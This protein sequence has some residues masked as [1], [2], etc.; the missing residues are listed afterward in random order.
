MFLSNSLLSLWCLWCGL[1]VDAFS[2]LSVRASSDN[3]SR[4][5]RPFSLS[6][7]RQAATLPVANEVEFDEQDDETTKNLKD[8]LELD[9]E[10]CLR[11]HKDGPVLLNGL[12]PSVWTAIKPT[13][14]EDKSLFLHTIHSKEKHEH[15]VPLGDLVSCHRLLACSRLTRYWMGPA[16]GTS[17]K[18]VP[19][20]TQFLL[21]E[22]S[23]SE[24]YQYALLLPL[25]DSGFRASLHYS[26]K[27]IEVVCHTE[28][29]DA[30]VVSSGMRAL[31]VAVGDDPFA[32][33]KKGFAQVSEATGTFSTLDQ[34]QLPQ[35]V[36]DFGW[37]T[38]DAFYSKV[39]PEGVIKGVES[40]REAGVPPK[41]LILDDGWQQVKPSPPGWESSSVNG[42]KPNSIFSRIG[43]AIKNAML[44]PFVKAVEGFYEKFV[45]KASHGSIGNKIWRFLTKTILKGQMWEYFDKETDFGRQLSGF[46][47]NYKFQE[48]EHKD[49]KSLKDLVAVLKT[50]LGIKQVY[51]WHALHGYW[52]GIS[53]SA[54]MNIGINVTKVHPSP[55][56]HL[57]RLEPQVAWDT[58][59]LFGVGLLTSA[60]DLATF[61]RHIHTP[62]VESGVDGVKVSVFSL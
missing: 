5:R 20:D 23:E 50:Q 26:S 59:C 25:V 2:G 47:P 35:S 55:S 34:K 18:D 21:V 14:G 36:N 24:P 46:T 30:N 56:N 40:L 60:S 10:G 52:L 61:Y 31:Y 44:T 51:C 38:W 13:S 12:D 3:G 6:S 43:N 11:I 8:H 42:V 15:E 39:T 29:G 1:H 49:V 22:I 37:C 33:L 9:R 53:R 16:F 27:S 45:R 32:L 7:I 58:A 19:F 57:L 4:S 62:L 54:G 48:G 41:T 17:S 28:S